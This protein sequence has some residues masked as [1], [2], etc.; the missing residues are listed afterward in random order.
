V[1]RL[2]AV[3]ARAVDVKLI[4]AS[5]AVLAES[6]VSGRFRADRYHRLA[7]VVL[8]LPPLRARGKDVM[9]LAEALLRHYTT[10]HGVPAKHLSATA[11]TW[12][13]EYLW[14]GNVREL[15][16]VMERMTLLHVG[17]EVDAETLT[18][19]CQPLGAL[20]P[21]WEFSGNHWNWCE[22]KLC[23]RRRRKSGRHWCKAGAMCPERRGCWG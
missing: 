6:V 5:N 21:P 22:K 17:A 11:Q 4:A 2:G 14:P 8:A 18:S 19:L 16:H 7:V 13:R 10:A 12:L 1:R 20:E 3:A 9:L 23:H 15:G